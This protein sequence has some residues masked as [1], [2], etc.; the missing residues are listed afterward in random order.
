MKESRSR[1]TGKKGKWK[2][3]GG[4]G[5][6]WRERGKKN[7]EINRVLPQFTP[8]SSVFHGNNFPVI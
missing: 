3:G 6:G 8:F 2:G 7:D 5:K 1:K 4:K